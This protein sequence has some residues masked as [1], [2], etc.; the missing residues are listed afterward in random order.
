MRSLE[1]AGLMINLHNEKDEEDSECGCLEKRTRT[2][3]R[4]QLGVLV[5]PSS[6]RST[7]SLGCAFPLVVLAPL[8]LLEGTIQSECVIHLPPSARGCH[9]QC[10]PTFL[11]YC[12]PIAVSCNYVHT[13]QVGQCI[14]NSISLDFHKIPCS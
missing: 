10:H 9:K 5:V 14:C 8:A 6:A 2:E 3:D 11:Q 4:I 1:E 7:A 13:R 12:I